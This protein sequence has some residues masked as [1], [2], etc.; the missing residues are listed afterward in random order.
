MDLFLTN[1]ASQDVNWW[2]GVMWSIVMFLSAHSDG[3][4]SLQRIHW[5]ASDSI[6]D[7]SK[8][9]NSWWTEGKSIFIK[10]QKRTHDMTYRSSLGHTSEDFKCAGQSSPKSKISVLRFKYVSLKY[11]VNQRSFH[12]QPKQLQNVCC[13]SS[14]SIATA[15]LRRSLEIKLHPVTSDQAWAAICLQAWKPQ[16][17]EPGLQCWDSAPVCIS[18]SSGQEWSLASPFTGRL[19]E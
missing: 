1:M 6:L 7:F 8:E 3:T 10:Y 16:R 17:S 5:W 11:T 4:H 19:L 13:I 14:I 9:T 18:L 12:S 15:V 2:T